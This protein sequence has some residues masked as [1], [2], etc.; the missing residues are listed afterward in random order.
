MKVV[1]V[2]LVVLFLLYLLSTRGR[3]EHPEMKNLRGWSYAHRG[4]HGSG[5][6][7]NSMAAFRKALNRGYGIEL[8]IHLLADG[9]LAVLHDS[10]LKRITGAEGRIEDLTVDQLKGFRLDGTEETIP[11]F[12]QVLE[13]IAGRVPLIIELKSVGKNYAA[14]C[15]KACQM[16][17]GYKGAYCMESFDPRCL[18]WLKKHRPDVIRG[19]LTEDYF[20]TNGLLSPVMKFL[21][22][23]QMLNFMTIPD[24]VAYRYEHS[25][26]FSNWIVRKIWRV[27]GVTWTLR[28][29]ADYN[30]AV[31][32]GWIPI[33]ENFTP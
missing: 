3:R 15:S 31:E 10:E 2:V 17:D 21:L 22:T 4:L 6:P 32:N 23:H 8:D 18:L 26:N 33:F 9:D 29:N 12:R 30:A 7:E 14:L 5:C 11:E 27:Q 20:K 19:Q 28:S 25:R 13:M 24:F 16:M 1:V